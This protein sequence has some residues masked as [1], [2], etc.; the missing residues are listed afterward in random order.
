MRWNT[1][2]TVIYKHNETL[3]LLCL[4]ET[5][6]VPISSHIKVSRR[7][8]ISCKTLKT[9]RKKCKQSFIGLLRTAKSFISMNRQGPTRPL[10]SLTAYFSENIKDRNVKFWNYLDTSFQF[11][12]SKFRSI[13]SIVWKLCALRHHSH[14]V[15]F[16][17]FFSNN[18]QLENKF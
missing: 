15:N 3:H 1:L 10:H 16:S 8:S 17:H 18:L 11:M 6:E 5:N 2:Y 9:N 13:S 12:L 7:C 4:N 14:F